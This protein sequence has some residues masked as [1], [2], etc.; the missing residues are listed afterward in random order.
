[1]I[2]VRRLALFSGALRALSDLSPAERDAEG[3]DGARPL[4]VTINPASSH[5]RTIP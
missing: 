2:G 3:Y 5:A 1:M 4:S